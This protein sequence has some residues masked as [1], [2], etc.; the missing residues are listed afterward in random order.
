MYR[1]ERGLRLQLAMMKPNQTGS[2][3]AFLHPEEPAARRLAVLGFLP[4]EIFV[5][6]RIRPEFLI[7]YGYTRIAINR[8]LASKIIVNIL[9]LT[10]LNRREML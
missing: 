5:L 9:T 4:G 10:R 2:V 7:R 6:E 3:S 1:Q 8:R